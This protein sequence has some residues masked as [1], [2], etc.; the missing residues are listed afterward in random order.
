MAR[1]L[2]PEAKERRKRRRRAKRIAL[3]A[4]LVAFILVVSYGIVAVIEAFTP[5]NEGEETLINP[6]QITDLEPNTSLETEGQW[7]G[8]VGPVQQTINNFEIVAPDH[9]MLQLPEN[10]SVDLSYFE[11]VTFVGDSLTEGLRIYSAIENSVA[12]ISTFVSAKSLSPKSF[13][14]GVITNFEN[15]YRPAQ[16]GVE[17]IIESWPSKVYIT[18]GTNA[19]VYMT[20]EQF[21]YYY[22][23]LLTRLKQE[24]PNVLFYVCSVTPTTAEY[25][26]AKPNFSW[27]RMY[28]V[29]NQIAKMCS[30]KGMHYINL[31]EVL[32]GDDGYLK[33]EYEAN[34]GD[35]IHLKPAAYTQWVQ[36]LMTHTVHDKDNPYI[37]GSPYYIG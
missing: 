7:T 14:E 23:Q 4:F 24:M 28:R 34:L 5:E 15:N 27:D 16:N 6:E 26:A 31:H 9:R 11:N 36:Y 17:A 20:D 35:G 1:Y 30:E 12:N 25:A 22:D 19:L 8:F 13:L 2:S 10:G 33:P 18:L 3:A 21:I 32:A 37:P 29:N